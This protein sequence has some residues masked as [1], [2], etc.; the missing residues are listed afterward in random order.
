MPA[1]CPG[2][3]ACVTRVHRRSADGVRLTGVLVRRPR[4]GSDP[5]G[6]PA[7]V[8]GHG[9]T[10]HVRKPFVERIL[11]QIEILVDSIALKVE[12]GSTDPRLWRILAGVY[13]A[14]ERIAD[15]NDLVRKLYMGM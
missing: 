9:F 1:K 13:L 3:D 11:R 15:Y 8:V 7:V 12:F 14:N 4:R 5:A 10:N 6:E 2:R